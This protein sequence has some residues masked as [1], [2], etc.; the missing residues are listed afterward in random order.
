LLIN[1]NLSKV[2]EK[3]NI[4][5]LAVFGS[6]VTVEF[7]EQTELDL[8]FVFEVGKVL[9]FEFYHLVE[10]LK[11]VFNREVDLVEKFMLHLII[12]N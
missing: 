11:L 2:C 1:N 12:E 3:Y 9:G 4:A 6:T 7:D 8:L 5:W 10:D